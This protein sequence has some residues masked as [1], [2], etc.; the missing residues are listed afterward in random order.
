MCIFVIELGGP[1]VQAY[2]SS[3]QGISYGII[4]IFNLTWKQYSG[5]WVLGL[6][7]GY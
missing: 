5:D 3:S 2:F 1:D 7:I 6:N 4:V